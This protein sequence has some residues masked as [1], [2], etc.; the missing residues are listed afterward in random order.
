MKD[1]PDKV[2]A[3][4]G[5]SGPFAM[6]KI[7]ELSIVQTL[8]KRFPH[9]TFRFDIERTAGMGYYSSLCFKITATNETGHKFPLVDGGMS[10][11]TQKILSSRKERFFSSGIG[12]ELF[13][14][15]FAKT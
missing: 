10:D 9:V 14:N 12:S 4:Y 13:C 6:L 2:T 11:W 8:Q 3:S 15:L 1:I 7:A 5:L